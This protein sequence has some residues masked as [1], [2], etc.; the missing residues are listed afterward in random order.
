MSLLLPVR[1]TSYCLRSSTFVRTSWALQTRLKAALE[2]GNT[3]DQPPMGSSVSEGSSV[4]ICCPISPGETL[5][6]SMGAAGAAESSGN[7]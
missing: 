6:A 5:S 3:F 4:S 2:P 1:E 7:G